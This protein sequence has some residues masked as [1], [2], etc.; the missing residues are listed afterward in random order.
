VCS[1]DLTSAVYSSSS[2]CCSYPKDK[3]AKLEHLRRLYNENEYVGKLRI[4]EAKH[5][6]IIGLNLAEVDS[7][8][9]NCELQEAIN[10]LR[11]RKSLG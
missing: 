8:V 9:S 7:P 2:A 3:R 6:N 1:S 4:E 11:N 5:K 10:Q